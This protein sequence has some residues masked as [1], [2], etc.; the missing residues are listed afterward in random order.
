[1]KLKPLVFFILLLLQGNSLFS[2]MGASRYG[3]MVKERG[4]GGGL[5]PADSPVKE[6]ATGKKG[7]SSDS[8]VIIQQTAPERLPQRSPDLSMHTTDTTRLAA[9]GSLALPRSLNQL[10]VRNNFTRNLLKYFITS[11]VNAVDPSGVQSMDYFKLFGGKKIASIHFVRLH[12]FGTSMQDTS[13]LAPSWIGNAGN[14]LHMNTSRQKLAMQLL[15]EAGDPVNPLL[16]AENEKLMRDLSYLEDVS[17]RLELS[18]INP[19]EVNLFVITKDKFEYGASLSLNTDNSNV[20]VINEN[21][22]GMGHRLHIGLAQKNRYLPEMGFY[23]S[24]QVNN[25]LGKFINSSAEFS[26]TYLKKG[27]NFSVEKLFLTSSVENSGGFSFDHVAKYNYIAEDHPIA[28]DTVVSYFA[29]DMWFQHAFT[30]SRDPSNKLLVSFRY[31]H[32]LFNRADDNTYGQSLFLRNH[33]FFLTGLGFT[34]R[35]LYKNNLVYGYGVT[36]DIPYGYYHELLAGLDK[37]QFGVWPYVGFSVSGAL[38]DKGGNYFGGRLAAD[39]FLDGGMV[40]QGTLLA[41]ANF[42]SHKFFLLDDPFRG[43]VR[44]EFVGGIN[45]LKEEYL[46]I[47]GRFGIRDF[48]SRIKGNSR[49]RINLE[50]VRYLKWNFYGFRF[51]NYYFTDL[52]FLSDKPG[53]IFAGNF[54]AGVGTGFRIFNESLVF[55]IIDIRLSWFPVLPAGMNPFGTNLQGLVKTRFDDFLGRKS[56]VIRYQ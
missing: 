24:Y 25:I 41:S 27:W 8:T 2:S 22:F 50:M 10:A 21:M 20:E 46:T 47:D 40:R 17:F 15:F 9:G 38:I 29:S 1:M 51:T 14:R 52:A 56:E 11:Q 45:R 3:T 16:M 42:F 18:E 19:E 54:Y 31:Y 34:R 48:Y 12:P 39:G 26:D 13:L 49:I 23:S 32:Q 5:R 43:F 55:K 6:E 44:I 37:S 36:E 33:D 53:T 7:A 35:N 30:G 28:L 4:L